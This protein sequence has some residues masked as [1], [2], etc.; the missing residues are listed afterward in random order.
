MYGYFLENNVGR[1]VVVDGAV[2][3]SGI[4]CL[5]EGGRQLL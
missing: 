2:T 3:K 1:E 4:I 5:A